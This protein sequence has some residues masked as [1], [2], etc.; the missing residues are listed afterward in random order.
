KVLRDLLRMRGQALAIALVIS[1]GAA[2]YIM[3][4]RTLDTLMA[5]R[6]TYYRNYR[7]ADVFAELKRA[8]EYIREQ[9]S[10]IPGVQHVET[11]VVAAAILEIPDF[12]EP[13][14]AQIVSAPDG[15]PR[16]N[17]L[18]LRAGRLPDPLRENE[19]V[20]S[21]AFADAH[22]F[23]P[24]GRMAATINGRHRRLEIVGI[25]LSP[26]YIFQVQPGSP[27]PDFKSFGILWMSEEP[28]EAA[29]NM[30][31][32]FNNVTLSLT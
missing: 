20:V 23:Q 18:F 1:S 17:Q 19:V 10:A 29:Y 12:N 27:I 31:G 14:T 32:A 5:T 16:L 26:E 15:G 4:V 21:E 6:E 9:S 11:R 2:T 28:L 13:V 25:A 24:G 8:P 30:E 7:L 22:G 3:S